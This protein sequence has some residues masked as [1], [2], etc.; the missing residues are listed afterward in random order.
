MIRK[1]RCMQ[2]YHIMKK[3]VLTLIITVQST[4]LLFGQTGTAANPYTSLGQ[5]WFV[6]SSGVYHFNIGSTTFSTYVEAGNGWILAA[7]GDGS[8]AESSYGT[9]KTLSLQS[10]SILPSSIYTSSLI[11]DVRMNAT[12][13]PSTPFDVQ[14]SNSGVLGNLQNDRTLSNGT[15][16]G[17]WIGTGT[18]RLTRSCGGNTQSLSTHIYHACGNSGNMHWQ[19]GRNT[20][21]E[22]VAFSNSTKNDL[23][24]WIRA[25]SAPLPIVLLNFSAKTI[26]SRVKLH[27]QTLSEINNDFFSVERS[28]DQVNWETIR[29]LDGA[30]NS[31]I[32][33]N[34][35]IIDR[36]PYTGLSYYRLKQK[37]YDGKITYSQ[38]LSVNIKAKKKS[39][40]L[41]F[42][43]PSTDQITITGGAILTDD[44]K[45]FNALYQDVTWLAS[46][47]DK[48]NHKLVI[49]ISKLSTGVYYIK[50]KNT[51]K[52][53]YKQ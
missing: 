10:D 26:D 47:I 31:S 28:L 23:N 39:R 36:D 29:I 11:T 20:T 53:I 41:V 6:P 2:L 44:I 3:I 48:N 21:H 22:K 14:S 52:K 27:W 24:L 50:T 33:V 25:A 37:D 40:L 1:R 42:P 7:S 15:N 17:N 34:Y 19:V 30:G 45:I 8:T 12:S 51:A 49:N 43:N 4:L 13:G 5:A 9:T 32:T 35:D 46:V 16:S 38:I 18:A